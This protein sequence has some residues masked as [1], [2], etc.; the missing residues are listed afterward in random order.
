M[1]SG[2]YDIQN[3]ELP[4]KPDIKGLVV[5][6]PSEYHCQ[7]LS[8]EVLQVWTEVAGQMEDAGAQVS[9]YIEFIVFKFLSVY[10]GFQGRVG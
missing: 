9:F 1:T 6:I 4:D 5:G 10:G 8:K 2:N 3:S 7:G